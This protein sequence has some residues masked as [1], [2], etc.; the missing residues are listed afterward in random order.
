MADQVKTPPSAPPSE[1]DLK[2]FDQKFEDFFEKLSDREKLQ[3]ASLATLAAAE[4][5]DE[6]AQQ[7]GPNKEAKPLSEQEIEEFADK[8][9]TF[10]DSLP[11]GQHQILDSMAAKA[12]A[13][14]V[15]ED[16]RDDVE[17]HWWAWH[18]WV[19]YGDTRYRN[20]L[21]S[22][23]NNQGGSLYWTGGSYNTATRWS[24]WR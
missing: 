21:Q 16:E 18:R 3:A 14:I 10:H 24:C 22:F 23:C 12:F 17:G 20:Y 4:D 15:P 8:L 2:E 13:Q 5:G 11:D 6:Q 19:G 7:V 1:Q 9:Q